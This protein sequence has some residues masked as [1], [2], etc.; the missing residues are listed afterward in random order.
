VREALRRKLVVRRM[1]AR[2]QKRALARANDTWAAHAAEQK[3]LKL[4]GVKVVERIKNRYLARANDTWA[5]HAAEHPG[6]S[7]RG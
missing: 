6:P 5:L 4:V 7:G 3:R 1:L 2:M